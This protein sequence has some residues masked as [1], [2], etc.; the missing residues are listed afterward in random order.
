MRK[1]LLFAIVAVAFRAACQT[2]APLTNA[3]IVKLCKAGLGD[4]IVIAKI[5]GAGK[6]AFALDTDSLIQL[7]QSGV[8]Q[9]VISAM[10]RKGSGRTTT[11]TTTV[12][13][14]APA[15]TTQQ[16]DPPSFEA[17]DGT[18]GMVIAASRFNATGFGPIKMVHL[19]IA[20]F[21]SNTRT[22]DPSPSVIIKFDYDPQTFFFFVRTEPDKTDNTR[23]V[24]MGSAMQTLKK[25]F[26]ENPRYYPD[27]NHTVAYNAE[28]ISPGIWRMTPKSPLAPGEYGLYFSSDFTSKYRGTDTAVYDF[29]IVAATTTQPT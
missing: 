25:M 19:E 22:V 6:T 16:D 17:S 5:E 24:K 15:G 27:A 10:L 28:Q 4:D 13:A 8:S 7:K 12:V 23:S 3:E 18:R 26:Q 11:A 14:T 1:L 21:S 20:G 9:P 29:A 2:E